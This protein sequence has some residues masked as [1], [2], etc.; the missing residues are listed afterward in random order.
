MLR[1]KR[2]NI[3]NST[4]LPSTVGFLLIISFGILNTSFSSNNQAYATLEDNNKIVD[5]IKKVCPNYE[6]NGNIRGLASDIFE[7]CLGH[8]NQPPATPGPNPTAFP[9]NYVNFVATAVAFE[10]EAFEAN[11]TIRD[12]SSNYLQSY[13]LSVEGD[14]PT[15]SNEK[16]TDE[17]V[18]PVGDEFGVSVAVK[19]LFEQGPYTIAL[20]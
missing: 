11:I 16:V 14:D 13:L 2:G 15:T 1:L 19:S 7:A 9:H 6:G 18:I 8:N 17:F 5:S 20:G 4:L 12:N 3:R 10:D